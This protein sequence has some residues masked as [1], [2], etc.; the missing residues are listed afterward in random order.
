MDI[1]SHAV[2][3]LAVSTVISS[4][5]KVKFTTKLKFWLTGIFAAVLPDFDV[6]SLWSKFDQTLG[7][8]LN[9]QHTGNEIYFSKFWYSHHA[10][11]H[12]LLAALIFGGT[13]LALGTLFKRKND[14]KIR[15]CLLTTF[16]LAY[17]AHLFGDMPTPASVWGGVKLFFPYD[18][19]IGGFG[20]I[21]WWN[22]YDLF[23]IMLLVV[24]INVGISIVQ[25]FRS[26][27]IKIIS[28][29]TFAIGLTLIMIQ[30]KS[31][32]F[33]FSYEGHTANY[34]QFE[35]QSQLLQQE[36]LGTHLYKMMNDFDKKLP[37]YF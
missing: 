4:Q 8:W 2:S 26:V 13:F 28:L 17:S 37:F 18:E 19:Y 1:L 21:W 12:S 24:L 35:E 27:Q 25:E 30:I 22:N 3:G 36:I 16:I 14:L 23:M 31:R 29:I 33:D 10:F 20:N 9:L 5:I 6:L 34:L 15:M 32:P 11:M 7:I